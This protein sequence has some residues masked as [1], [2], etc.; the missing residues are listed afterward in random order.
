[1]HGLGH[2]SRQSPLVVRV[3]EEDDHDMLDAS[4]TPPLPPLPTRPIQPKLPQ[5]MTGVPLPSLLTP[6]SK[7]RRVTLSGGH[8]LGL[9]T[10]VKAPSLDPSGTTPISPAVMGFTIGRDDPAAIEQVRSMLT[11]KQ[12]QKALIE[13]RRGSV[14]GVVNANPSNALSNEHRRGSV[15]GI[16]TMPSTGDSPRAPGIT[17]LSSGSAANS[18]ED[19]PVPKPAASVRSVRRSPNMGSIASSSRRVA[20]VPAAPS[21]STDGRPASPGP[22]LVVVPSQPT[23]LAPNQHL[24]PPPISFAR[25]RAGQFGQGK[26]KPADIVIKRSLDTVH[27]NLC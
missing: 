21:Q 14:A 8:V 11:V 13:Q 23:P 19:R 24:P 25:R 4:P 15:A 5:D 2:V 22:N 10:D 3:K 7:K 6:P 26:N 1:M 16:L 20:N 27:K 9:N 17:R 12:K 18:S